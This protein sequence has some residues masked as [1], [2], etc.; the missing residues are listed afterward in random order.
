MRLTFHGAAGMV[1]GS[2]H[3]LETGNT[4][5]LLDCGMFQGGDEGERLNRRPF[6]FAPQEIDFVL[7][8]HAHIDHS[9]LLP[10]LVKEGFQ[11]QI[12]TTE[13][14]ADLLTFLLPDSGHIQE[15]EAERENRK[16]LRAGK[17]PVTPLYTAEEARAVQKWVKPVPYEKLIPLTPQITCR[18]LDAGHILGSAVIE[19]WAEENGQTEKLVFT[20]DLGNIGQAILKDPTP[21]EET[22]YLI[23]ESTYGGRTHEDRSVKGE[24]L[25]EIINATVKRGGNI[26]IPAFA[27]ERT[28][29][30]LY[31]LNNL[32]EKG[33]I[34]PLPVFVDSPLASSTTEI[35]RR[36]PECYDEETRKLLAAGDD[37]FYFRGLT[38]TKTAEE[39]K[40]IN[41]H[42]GSAIIL[43]A[44]GMCDAGRIRH[45]LKHNLWRPESTVLFVGY[46]APGTL[47]RILLD[48]V[49]KVKLFGEQ[50]QV[51]A[52]IAS[53]D[54]FS[55]HADH[56]GLL[57]WV[58]RLKR[59]PRAIFVVHGEPRSSQR[60][61]TD[62]AVRFGTATV[63]APALGEQIDLTHVSVAAHPTTIR[64]AVQDIFRQAVLRKLESIEV[65]VGELK[66]MLEEE[67]KFHHGF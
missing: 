65:L 44:S 40:A 67:E 20:G 12:Y 48:G 1:T 23:I 14:T 45:H 19:I 8:S 54:G 13:A 51:R 59:A 33:E 10:K 57:N 4:K 60:L 50:I 31:E 26:V 36:H 25:K 35:F 55:G 38:F 49:K 39:S 34:P 64:P 21:V 17:E 3:L 2:C 6:P 58:F 18:F 32:A 53:I 52:Q 42:K 46:Q 37:P 15:A 62:I 56:G 7:L 66:S 41:E 22:D 43:S 11:G 9:G 63:H 24:K 30:L 29:E 16:R 28:Q 5:I 27:V 61:V 47:G